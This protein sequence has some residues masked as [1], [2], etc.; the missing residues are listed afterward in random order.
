MTGKNALVISGGGA[1]GAW[2]VG[3]LRHLLKDKRQKFDIAVGTSTGALISP[4]AVLGDID[5]L[6]EAYTT[7]KKRD[8][9]GCRFTGNLA[10]NALFGL[11]SGKD[12]VFSTGPLRRR[13]EKTLD[14]SRWQRLVSGPAEAWVSVVNLQ[15]GAIEY[16]GSHQPN[17]KRERFIEA[18]VA[19][20]SIPVFMS[21][22]EI[23]SAPG[24]SFVDGGVRDLIP[25][26]QAIRLGARDITIIILGPEPQPKRKDYNRLYKMLERTID[27][28]GEETATNDIEFG[29][30]VTR[31]VLWRRR[32]R[33]NLKAAGLEPAKVDAGFERTS[34]QD[35]PLAR[36]DRPYEAVSFRLI[37]PAGSLGGTLDFD[38]KR[39]AES[40]QAGYDFASNLDNWRRI[41]RQP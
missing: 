17:M 28:Q 36:D 21:R 2:A 11:F 1:K 18:M 26:G 27:L 6:V 40:E 20:A 3:V 30:L 10:L 19:S 41:P 12:S 23:A 13:V 38:P 33:E 29:Q 37:R 22:A 9:L 16:Y 34:K 8:I 4:L 5:D 7:V 39:M 25:L 14:G 24:C 15:T 35:E 31:E 32:L